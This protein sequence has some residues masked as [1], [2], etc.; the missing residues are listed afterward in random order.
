MTRKHQ[1]TKDMG[2]QGTLVLLAL[3]CE[4]KKACGDISCELAIHCRTGTAGSVLIFMATSN[5]EK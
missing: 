2:P 3:S 5:P 1:G 4:G